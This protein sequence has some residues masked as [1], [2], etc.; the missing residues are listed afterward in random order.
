MF[1]KIAIIGGSGNVGSHIAF[2]GAIRGIAREIALFSIDTPRCK[3]VGLDIS[4]AAAVFNLPTHIKGYESYEG[5]SESEVVIITAG[6]PRT[7]NMTRDDLLLKNASIVREISQN[8][9]KIAPDALLLIVSNPLDAMCLV[10]KHASGF[11]SQRV[12]G[13]A[14][15]L[16]GARLNYESKVVLNDFQ[17]PIKPYV[18]GAHSDD[19]LPLLR[20]SLYGDKPLAAILDSDMQ[21][22]LIKETKNGGAKIVS[23]YQQGSAYFAPASAA[24]KMLELV[25]N[26]QDEDIVCS[27][28]VQGEYDLHDIYIGLPVKLGKKGV[29]KIVNLTLNKQEQEM[30]KISAQGIKKQVEILKNNGLLN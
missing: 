3:G 19:M 16:D 8:I 7:P 25:T 18:L 13:M 4:Q 24:I 30:L 20:F 10:A 22:Y 26:P 15:V 6:I 29:E 1:N 11:D 12:V 14:G 5:L 17:T 27:V 28:Y 2:L 21:Q 9:A 23:Y